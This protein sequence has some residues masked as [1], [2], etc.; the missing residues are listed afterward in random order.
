M[1]ND[2]PP[3][4]AYDW[5]PDPPPFTAEEIEDLRRNGLDLSEVIASILA[6]LE[7]EPGPDR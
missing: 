7:A 2:A 1:P 4:D 5:G 6:E 3:A